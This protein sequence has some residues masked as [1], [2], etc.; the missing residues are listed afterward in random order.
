[1]LMKDE[2][3][4]GYKTILHAV[5]TLK[6]DGYVMTLDGLAFLLVGDNRLD[7]LA[8]N[9]SFGY[10]SSLSTRKIKGRINYLIRYSYLKLD[11]SKDLDMHFLALTDKAEALNL[12]KL[13]KKETIRYKNIYYLKKENNK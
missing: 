13:V 10:L 8:E 5:Y 2:L 11:Y 3:K 1:M 9:P 7:D 12:K 6:E 4:N